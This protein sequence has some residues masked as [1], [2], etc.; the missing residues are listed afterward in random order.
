MDQ[1]GLDLEHLQPRQGGLEAP[2]LL[3]GEV[4]VGL[5]GHRQVGPEAAQRQPRG[6]LHG[7]G[8]IHGHIGVRPHPVHAGVDLHVHGG[9]RPA[10]PGGPS[11]GLHPPGRVQGGRKAQGQG[12]V[13]VGRGGLG[14]QQHG[15]A[16]AGLPQLGPLLHQR[17]RQ[18]LG[19]ARQR[20]ARD[21]HRAVAVAVGLDHRAQPGGRRGA[22]QHGGV[23]PYGGEVHL[24]PAPP[25]GQ[26]T[27]RDLPRRLRS[28]PTATPARGGAGR[29]RPGPDRARAGRRPRGCGPP[30][31]RPQTCRGPGR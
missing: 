8:Q 25:A 18:P 14:Q 2:H 31:P 21:R 24:G 17:H 10:E 28:R 9:G 6:G 3:G 7:R 5:V 29:P 22:G 20:G 13:H 4:V 1:G 11:R 16:D 27:H 12:L 15:R 26:V 19:A 23:V 30:A